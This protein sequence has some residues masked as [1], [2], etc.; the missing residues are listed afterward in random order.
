MEEF[1]PLSTQTIVGKGGPAVVVV[2][3]W[4]I[5]DKVI[6]Q[7]PLNM[8]GAIGPL[9]NHSRGI[10]LLLRSLLANPSTRILVCLTGTQQ[11][12]NAGSI[13]ALKAFFDYG[14]EPVS[15]S[16]IKYWQIKGI[17]FTAYID[18]ALPLEALESIRSTI[19]YEEFTTIPDLVHFLESLP[20]LEQ[21]PVRPRVLI[22]DPIKPQG[23]IK[24][25]RSIGHSITGSTIGEVWLEI[26][27]RIRSTGVERPTGY[28]GSWQEIINLSATV[29]NERMDREFPGYL[30]MRLEDVHNYIPYITEAGSEERIKYT[31]GTRIRNHFG[32][33]QLKLVVDKLVKEPDAAS[34]VITLWD[35]N[36]HIVGGSPCLNHIWLRIRESR[37][38][39][40]ATF[41]SNDMFSAWPLNACGLIGLQQLILKEL[42]EKGLNS[43][44]IGTLTTNSL[45]AHIYS[46]CFSYADSILT[47]HR[48]KMLKE[49]RPD[50]IGDFVIG[51]TSEGY[52]NVEH[53]DPEKGG[54]L[55]KVYKGRK[56]AALAKEIVADNPTI[57]PAHAAYLGLSLQ[58][59]EM[60]KDK[61]I[62]Q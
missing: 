33:D 59:A 27:Y 13:E 58:G 20:N 12:K 49:F 19:K 53:W 25:G 61:Y 17:P 26:I 51:V 42:Q 39:M 4:T 10:T 55:V 32:K 15:V 28:D 36:D 29:E 57:E 5:T 40:V 9:Y 16:G 21:A 8:Y 7:A 52:I 23:L 2:T 38:H 47:A 3:G 43:L 1:K 31:Y 14:V 45:S 54:I 62:Q 35:I 6:K 22:P 60:K 44:E 46:D 41:R 56:A 34:A 50:K 37:L 11:D 48:S 24:P 30:P 18:S